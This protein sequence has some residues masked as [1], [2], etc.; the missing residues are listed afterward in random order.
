MAL[1]E[2]RAVVCY[3]CGTLLGQLE[4]E[5]TQEGMARFREQA[6]AM[7]RDHA[8]GLQETRKAAVSAGKR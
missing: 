6:E 7:K 4:V 8:C 3:Q 1:K 5:L 2:T